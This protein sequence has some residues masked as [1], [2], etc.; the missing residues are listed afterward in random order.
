MTASQFFTCTSC[1]VDTVG[2]YAILIRE[3]NPILIRMGY[4]V[5]LDGR[6]WQISGYGHIYTGE[7]VG[8]A[9]R[10]IEHLTGTAEDS[11]FRESLIALQLATGAIWTDQASRCRS[12]LEALLSDW[13]AENAMV[14]FKLCKFVGE[15]ERGILE[16]APSPLNIR[17]HLPTPFTKMLKTARKNF[18]IQRRRP[19]RAKSRSVAEPPRLLHPW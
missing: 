8:V 16:R 12:R 2:V 14:A 3:V 5:A 1:I 18:G 7:S 10:L 6:L 17:D 13:L 9:S 15:V 19:I 4:D 11:T